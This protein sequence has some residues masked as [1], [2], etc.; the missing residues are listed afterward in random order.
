MKHRPDWHI[1]LVFE[2]AL[3]Y[4]GGEVLL[5]RGQKVHGNE[6]VAQRQLASMHHGVRL[7]T[8]VIVVVLALETL[9]VALRVILCASVVRVDDPLCLTILF[10]LALAALLVGKF[11]HEVDESHIPILVYRNKDTRRLCQ[12]AA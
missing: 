2:L 8:L 12:T 6:P 11:P 10:Q 1:A 7:Q 5:R 3:E 9:L 4:S